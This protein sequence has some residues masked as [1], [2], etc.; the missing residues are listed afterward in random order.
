MIF[1]QL[2]TMICDYEMTGQL[3]IYR[4]Q[5][6]LGLEIDNYPNLVTQYL[7]T[8]ISSAKINT[9]TLIISSF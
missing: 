4:R 3:L 6:F 1:D 8:A 9:V 5:Y 2:F 7:Y